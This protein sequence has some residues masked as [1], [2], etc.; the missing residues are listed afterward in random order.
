MPGGES[1]LDCGRSGQIDQAEIVDCS[2]TKKLSSYF[3][4]K[5]ATYAG[6]MQLQIENCMIKI[7]EET[8]ASSVWQRCDIR[9]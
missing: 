3:N 1:V 7:S 2:D 4:A 6:E 8:V 9:R 5:L